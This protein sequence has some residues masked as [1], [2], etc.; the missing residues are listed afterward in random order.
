MHASLIS[1]YE[2]VGFDL[3][4]G[5][6]QVPQPLQRLGP[7]L[8]SKAVEGVLLFRLTTNLVAVT[9]GKAA[10][11]VIFPFRAAF[12]SARW[13]RFAVFPTSM[14]PLTV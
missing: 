13:K 4:T 5:P 6:A 14:R 7:L 3:G 9:E 11:T 8:N 1:S 12:T 2:H 10:E